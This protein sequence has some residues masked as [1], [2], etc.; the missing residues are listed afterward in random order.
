MSPVGAAL[1]LWGSLCLVA[2]MGCSDS[3]EPSRADNIASVFLEADATLLRERPGLVAGKY[4]RMAEDLFSFYRG[5]MP[6]WLSDAARG[7]HPASAFDLRDPMPVCIGDSHPENFGTLR[8]SDGTLAVEANDFDAADRTP[9]LWDLRRLTVGLV[10]AARLSNPDDP[11]ARAQAAAAAR[12]VARAAARSYAEA[13]RALA[14]GAV[15]QR[16]VD[17]EAPALEE[18]FEAATKAAEKRSE[19]DALTEVVGGERRLLRGVLDV[20]EPTHALVDLPAAARDELP[21]TLAAWRQTLVT[22][23]PEDHML[24][25]DA[26]REL[27][28][29]VASWPR[30]RALVLVEGPSDDLDDDLVL[31]VK[32]LAESGAPGAGWPSE[33]GRRILETT[34]ALWARPD[35]DPLWGVATWQGLPVQVR[36]EAA[37]HRNLRVHRLQGPAGKR[38][39]LIALGRDLGGLVGRMHGVGEGAAIA[40]VIGGDIEG[41][42]NEQAEASLG[43][44]DAVERDWGLFQSV[45]AERGPLLGHVHDPA[46]PP[47]ALRDL[48][49]EPPY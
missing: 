3:M 48:F 47:A 24:V 22:P 34:R 37:S 7:E 40:A 13:V 4:T 25:K 36:T 5:T 12:D 39:A 21:A 1:R 33:P 19:L 16:L 8:A 14:G 44:A 42:A 9:Y 18:L 6:L 26:A 46:A 35:A 27:G 23:P 45:L 31:E 32:E 49:T 11:G 10:L 38:K 2:T 30:V 43:L 20:A 29:G 17:P 28:T 41:F 15:A